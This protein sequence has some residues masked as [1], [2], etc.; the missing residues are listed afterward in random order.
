M[1]NFV[2]PIPPSYDKDQDLYWEDTENYI[3]YLDKE[4]VT[5]VM[6]TAGTSQYNLLSQPE[7]I[8]LN[9]C[10]SSFSRKKILGLPPL[11][12]LHLTKFID[13]QRSVLGDVPNTHFMALYADRFYDNQSIV[14]YF[15]SVVDIVGSPIYI[16]SM[17]M[18]SGRGGH[19]NYTSDILNE[20]FERNL[21]I[22]IKEE[23]NDVMAA[24]NFILDLPRDMDI[25]VAGGSMRR[26]QFLKNAGAKSFLSGVG[27]L[28]PQIERDYFRGKEES[29]VEK[30]NEL[31]SVF[32]KH[33]W[34]RSLRIALSLMDLGCNFDRMPWPNRDNHIVEEIKKVLIKIGN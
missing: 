28:F 2:V 14:D 8:E 10:V 33:G 17:F 24:Y 15:S 21:V 32:N 5:T 13:S 20:L 25:I 29:S 4:G 19:W 7:I 27:N 6:T 1:N 23:Y 11:P 16:H 18:R 34:H 3:N 22:G 12:Q 9:R 31:F 26:H 30:E